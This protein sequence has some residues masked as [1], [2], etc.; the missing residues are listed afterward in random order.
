MQCVEVRGKIHPKKK[1]NWGQ[2][3]TKTDTSEP[4][5]LDSILVGKRMVVMVVE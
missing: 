4:S 2:K 5:F 3:E 1:P